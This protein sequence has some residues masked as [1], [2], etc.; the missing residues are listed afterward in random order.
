M[1]LLPYVGF[2]KVLSALKIV[3]RVYNERSVSHTSN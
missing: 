2:P 3:K 1:H